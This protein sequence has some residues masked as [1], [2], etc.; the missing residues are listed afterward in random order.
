MLRWGF[1]KSL[2]GG[3]MLGFLYYNNKG[4]ITSGSIAVSTCLRKLPKSSGSLP[5]E[6]YRPHFRDG[7]HSHGLGC[8][9]ESTNRGG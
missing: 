2:G 3:T 4:N 1:L 9:R 5:C 8:C 7:D 6:N